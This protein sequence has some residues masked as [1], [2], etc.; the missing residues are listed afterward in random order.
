MHD[1]EPYITVFHVTLKPKLFHRW[2]GM[3]TPLQRPMKTSS[4]NLKV[5]CPPKTQPTVR[6]IL[7]VPRLNVTD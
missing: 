3:R 5:S 7:T 1:I 2:E 4:L 6:Q